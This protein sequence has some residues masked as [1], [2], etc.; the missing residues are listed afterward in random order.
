MSDIEKPP[1]DRSWL[2]METRS[3][4]T[5]IWLTLLV[6]ASWLLWALVVALLLLAIWTAGLHWQFAGTAF[7]VGVIAA[8]ATGCAADLRDKIAEL[9][10][11]R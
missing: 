11:K 8:V 2:V 4:S 3:D 10:K 6:V 5:G 1:P 9:E 7:V